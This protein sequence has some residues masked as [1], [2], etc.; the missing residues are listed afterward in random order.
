MIRLPPR[1]T[2]TDSLLPYTTLFRSLL[3][4]FYA[5]LV[6][7]TEVPHFE[8]SNLLHLR[9]YHCPMAFRWAALEAEQHRRTPHSQ[10]NS[11]VQSCLCLRRREMFGIDIH[12]SGEVSSTHRVDRKSTRLN[13]S[14]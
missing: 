9:C 6:V 13:S 5:T 2:R 12:K 14:H 10:I 11:V 8:T 1:S 4:F 7:H 3:I